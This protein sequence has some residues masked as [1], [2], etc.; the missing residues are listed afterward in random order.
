MTT[1]QGVPIK[2]RLKPSRTQRTPAVM[3]SKAPAPA[4]AALSI[5]SS[6]HPASSVNSVAL[7]ESI[8]ID[9]TCFSGNSLRTSS[10]L[11]TVNL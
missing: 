8:K 10:G 9:E 1:G 11:S 5:F 3:P 2:A 7:S 6:S 4:T